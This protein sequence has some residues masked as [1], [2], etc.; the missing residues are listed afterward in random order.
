[1]IVESAI[2]PI[3]QGQERAFEAALKEA[4]P[5]NQASKGFHKIEV[6]RCVEDASRYL[7]LVWWET[8]EDHTIGFRQS[9]RYAKWRAALHR[10]YD[11][12]LTV[13]HYGEAVN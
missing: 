1:M 13:M 12:P 11:G 9:E 8:V 4:L 2:L 10:F 7:L 3:K 5:L 6:R